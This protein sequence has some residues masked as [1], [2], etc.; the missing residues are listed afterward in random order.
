LAIAKAV[1]LN[2]VKQGLSSIDPSSIDQR[3]QQELYDP[4]Y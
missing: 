3:I 2:A 1:M 4:R